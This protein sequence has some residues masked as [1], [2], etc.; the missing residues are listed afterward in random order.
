M[1][2]VFTI[3]VII[4]AISIM[5]VSPSSVLPTL[6]SGGNSGLIFSLKLFSIYAVWLSILQIWTKLRFDLWLGDKLKPL[7]HRLFPKENEACYGFLSINLSANMLG[8][9][10]AGTPAGIS[11]V[12]NMTS[13]KNRIML[14]VIN[15]S[16]V[17]IIPTTIIAMRSSLSSATDIILPSIIATFFST[18]IGFILVKVFVK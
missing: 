13:K 1:N 2:I 14:I 6:I 11:A 18:L 9:G 3:I 15:S 8:M 12:E 10:S 17:Q 4:S 16:S 7:L 5:F